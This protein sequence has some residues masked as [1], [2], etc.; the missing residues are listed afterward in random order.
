MYLSVLT[1]FLGSVKIALSLRCY[2]CHEE[3]NNGDIMASNSN[4]PVIN[5]NY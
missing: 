5:C 2:E 1:F 3:K 4:Y